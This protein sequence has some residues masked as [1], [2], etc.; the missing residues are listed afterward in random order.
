MVLFFIRK[1]SSLIKA[2]KF[3]IKPMSIL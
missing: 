1:S 2:M 3:W